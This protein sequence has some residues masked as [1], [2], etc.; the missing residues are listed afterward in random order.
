[1]APAAINFAWNY[2]YKSVTVF[3]FV[4]N[5]GYW[6]IAPSAYASAVGV[7]VTDNGKPINNF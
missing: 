3:T 6:G 2:I 4:V 1:L 7:F 5:Y